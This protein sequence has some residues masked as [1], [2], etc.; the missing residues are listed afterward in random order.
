MLD[1]QTILKLKDHSLSEIKDVFA[2]KISQG[3]N[4]KVFNEHIVLPP[5]IFSET[6]LEIIQY[7]ITE[8]NYIT[9]KKLTSEIIHLKYFDTDIPNINNKIILIE[10]ADPGYDWIFTKNPSG[11]ITKYG[12]VA[13]HMSIRCS[14]IGLPA[15]IGCGEILFEKLLLSSKILLDC[16]N[17][18]I[19]ILEHSIIDE[20]VEAKKKLKSLGYIK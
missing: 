5:I 9:N 10:N 19:V 1:I 18:Q 16:Q 4:K 6:D 17:E 15:A 12:G 7:H 2:V 3:K 20:D 8:P 14:E 13:S 11:L